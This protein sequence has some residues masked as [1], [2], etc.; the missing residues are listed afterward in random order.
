[1][2][3]FCFSARGACEFLVYRNCVIVT[4]I[5]LGH[6]ARTEGILANLLSDI[7]LCSCEQILYNSAID[8]VE[9]YL[10]FMRTFFLLRITYS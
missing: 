2:V 7:F 4:I 6:T 8:I 5:F 1:M 3:Q 10:V 9:F